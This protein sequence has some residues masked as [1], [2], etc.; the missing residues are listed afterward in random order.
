[1]RGGTKK[2]GGLTGASVV[3]ER[4]EAQARSKFPA[5]A[6]AN[7]AVVALSHHTSQH[8]QGYRAMQYHRA[9]HR[10]YLTLADEEGQLAA[11]RAV[12]THGGQTTMGGAKAATHA[13]HQILDSVKSWGRMW[14]DQSGSYHQPEATGMP[15][16]KWTRIIIPSWRSCSTFILFATLH[17]TFMKQEIRRSASSMRHAP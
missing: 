9:P 7:L 17:R 2:S 1:M 6:S 12:N 14:A 11:V 13:R 5:S 3:E 10:T 15:P 4:G 16:A 8:H